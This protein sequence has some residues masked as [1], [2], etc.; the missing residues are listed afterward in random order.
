M[1]LFLAFVLAAS[2][3]AAGAPSARGALD[4]TR[5]TLI[6][7]AGRPFSFVQLRGAPVAVTFVATRCTDECPLVD[8]WFVKAQRQLRRRHV[9]ASL[10]TITLDPKYDTP[11][12]MAAQARA[13]G[14]DPAVWR[15]A[16]GSVASVDAILS[17]FRVH[18][19]PD[20]HGIPDIH[21]TFVYILDARGK[22]ADL[23]LPSA[24][25]VDET[26]AAL[27]RRAVN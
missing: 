6:D 13:L 22:V 19:E 2:V 5:A 27:A 1:K 11:R 25:L 26:V 3:L 23:E 7:Q 4:P 8:A 16:S 24:D 18:V 10:L 9:R 12:V 21:T 17:A 14:A 20:A 15:F